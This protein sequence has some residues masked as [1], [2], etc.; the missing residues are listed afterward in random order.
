MINDLHNVWNMRKYMCLQTKLCS[1]T[2]S[3]RKHQ[4]THAASARHQLILMSSNY[5][6]HL[7]PGSSSKLSALHLSHQLLC[8]SVVL[9]R[10]SLCDFTTSASSS[11]GS[12]VIKS[13]CSGTVCCCRF[14]WALLCSAIRVGRDLLST[15]P[16]LSC[17]NSD[18]KNHSG[19]GLCLVNTFTI[20]SFY[21]ICCYVTRTVTIEPNFAFTVLHI[22]LQK[23]GEGSAVTT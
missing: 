10:C 11:S 13:S 2:I 19:Q 7:I 21:F 15:P 6:Q 23:V 22:A 20:M 4:F 1:G 16:I 5:F 8:H 14:W 18:R 17:A 9:P 12:L 3:G